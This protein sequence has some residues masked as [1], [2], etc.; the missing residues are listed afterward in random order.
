[1]LM[2]DLN[3]AFTSSDTKQQKLSLSL[4]C[5]LKNLLM[6]ADFYGFKISVDNEFFDANDRINI[7]LNCLKNLK[8]QMPEG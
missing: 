2:F 5:F 1:M 7:R 4:G 6:V 3:K 8:K